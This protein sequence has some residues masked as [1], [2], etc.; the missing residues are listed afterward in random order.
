MREDAIA[1]LEGPI[2]S[3]WM[4]SLTF[5]VIRSSLLG[6]DKSHRL[7]GVA[8]LLILDGRVPSWLLMCVVPSLPELSHRRLDV[9]RLLGLVVLWL[10]SH[11]L[12]NKKGMLLI[13]SVQSW[14]FICARTLISGM[15]FHN[16]VKHHKTQGFKSKKFLPIAQSRTALSIVLKYYRLDKRKQLKI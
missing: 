2:A 13:Y 14:A 10:V 15:H 11:I 16:F 1:S 4:T 5:Q 8:W 12:L 9:G 3:S 6:E 7:L